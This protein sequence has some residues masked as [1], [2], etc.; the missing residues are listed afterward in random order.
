MNHFFNSDVIWLNSV[1]STNEELKRRICEFKGGIVLMHDSQI[2][3]A[4]GID[5]WIN[6]VKCIG[7]PLVSIDPFM[8][9]KESVQVCDSAEQMEPP[10]APKEVPNLM[11]ILEGMYECPEDYDG[12]EDF[13]ECEVD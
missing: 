3:T 13:P 9:D 2:H 7:H 11:D 12:N 10:K 6:A 4:R 8:N 1:D 5:Q